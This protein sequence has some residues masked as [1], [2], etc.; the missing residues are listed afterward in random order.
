MCHEGRKRVKDLGDGRPRYLRKRDLKKL[1]MESIRILDM[2][3]S[4]TM[5]L[6]IAKQIAR[7]TVGMQKIKCWTLW[8]GQPPPKW[9]KKLQVEQELVM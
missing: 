8:R 2:T 3:F 7:S 4:K 1:R 6:E 5:R 9:E